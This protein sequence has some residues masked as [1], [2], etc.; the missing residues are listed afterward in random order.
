MLTVGAGV[1]LTVVGE[2]LDVEGA[3][4]TFGLKY[5]IS[6]ISFIISFFFFLN[7]FSPSVN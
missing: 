7:L 6:E 4:A 3:I 1:L 5:D 2:R